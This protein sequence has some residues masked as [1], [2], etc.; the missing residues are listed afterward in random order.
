MITLFS[1]IIGFFYTIS[2]PKE[3]TATGKIMPEIAYKATNGMG[4]LY[5]VLKK[6]SNNSDLYNTEITSSE[7]YAEILKTNDFYNYIFSKKIKATNNEQVSFEYYYYN[8]LENKNL[9]DKLGKSNSNTS[10]KIMRYS[11]IQDIQKRITITNTTK[12]N[13]VILVNAKMPD[14]VVAAEIVNFTIS[15]LTA[16]ITKY[17]TEK[18]RQD[19]YFIENLRKN[20]LNDSIKDQAVTKEIKNSLLASTIQMK[21]KI[22]EDTPIFQILEKAQIPV[23]SSNT[24]TLLILTVIIFIGF[25]IGILIAFLRDNNYKILF[26]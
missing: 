16:Y 12:K 26:Y 10:N 20:I 2:I 23:M 19:L 9:F 6:F 5:E 4:G 3:Y 24:P 14:P 8:I 7:L 1:A 25:L 13:S 18:A 21:I 15:Y 11:A 17:R 22:Q